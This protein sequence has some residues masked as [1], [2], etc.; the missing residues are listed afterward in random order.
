MNDNK[1]AAEEGRKLT[2]LLPAHLQVA[3]AGEK[4]AASKRAEQFGQTDQ[5]LAA[6]ALDREVCL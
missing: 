3:S 2:V 6:A 1:K 4:W 5:G